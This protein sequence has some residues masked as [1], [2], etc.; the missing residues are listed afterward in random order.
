MERCAQDTKAET[1]KTWEAEERERARREN[2]GD[3]DNEWGEEE[4][5]ELHPHPYLG[6]I[7]YKGPRVTPVNA[8]TTR[9]DFV[10]PTPS[11]RA[12]L[13][14]MNLAETALYEDG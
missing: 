1:A 7:G 5:V 11:A 2:D 6:T 4:T 8:F 3:S 13:P 14:S 10:A 9:K 12:E